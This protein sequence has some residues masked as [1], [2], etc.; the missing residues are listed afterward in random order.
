M[1]AVCCSSVLSVVVYCSLCVVLVAVVRGLLFAVSR[2]MIAVGVGC[3]L[4]R[5]RC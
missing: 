5:V 3:S 2:L 4:L 1:F